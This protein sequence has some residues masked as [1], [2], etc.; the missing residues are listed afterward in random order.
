MQRA[1]VRRIVSWIVGPVAAT[2]ML[3]TYSA[4]QTS[5]GGVGQGGGETFSRRVAPG[6]RHPYGVTFLIAP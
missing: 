2:L 5:M 6:R 3:V 4:A 1:D